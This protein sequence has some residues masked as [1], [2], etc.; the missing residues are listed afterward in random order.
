MGWALVD[1][2][3][4]GLL[5]EKPFNWTIPDRVVERTNI[6]RNDAAI[7]ASLAEL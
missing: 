1:Q 3:G 5:H 2:L 6:G 4:R 7:L